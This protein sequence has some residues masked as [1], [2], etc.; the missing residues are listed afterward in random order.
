MH[1]KGYK[2]IISLLVKMCE[3]AKISNE[4]T[5]FLFFR[6]AKSVLQHTIRGDFSLSEKKD[7]QIYPLVKWQD[8]VYNEV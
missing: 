6:P 3:Y 7:L 4:N 8:K 2:N 1:P 5:K